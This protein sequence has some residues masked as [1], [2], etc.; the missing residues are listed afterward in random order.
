MHGLLL[1]RSSSVKCIAVDWSGAIDQG[2]QRKNIWLAEAEGDQLVRLENGRTRKE[3]VSLLAEDILT[4]DNVVVGLDFA[5]S[6]PEWYLRERGIL[7][8]RGLWEL[9][10]RE[11]ENW[12][13]GN[14]WPF[15]GRPGAFS[16]RPPGLVT[17][18]R[19]R[20]TEGALQL[21]GLQPKSVFQIYGAGAVGTGTIRGLP[22]LLSLK[23]AGATIWP[24]DPIALPTVV[25]IYPRSLYGAEVINNKK[26]IGRNSRR[27][28]L[29]S[30]YPQIELHWRDI[31]I[32]NDNAFDAGVSALV[33]AAHTDSFHNLQRATDPTTSLE[34]EIWHP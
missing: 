22:W 18:Y 6:F 15:W 31:M 29:D 34:G 10:E 7:D 20:R 12:L 19:H 14:T 30:N 9:V 32:G 21:Q 5:F 16:K 11:G 33:M 23:D 1:K 27:K 17:H 13:E 3:V 26:P 2:D 25:E 28:Y 24:F 4:S 8:A